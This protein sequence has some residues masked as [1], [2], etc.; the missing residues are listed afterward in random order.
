MQSIEPLCER[1]EAVAASVDADLWPGEPFRLL[2]EEG[3]LGWVIPAEYGGADAS[4][5]E[6]MSGYERLS[7]ACLTTAFVLTQRNGACQRIAASDNETLK[8]ELLPGLARGEV[9]ATV[10]ISHLTTSRQHLAR[11]A[12]RLKATSDGY[13]AEGT[14]PWV[15][16]ANRAQYVVTGGICDDGLGVLFALPLGSPGINVQPPPRLL[17][18]NGSQT[19]SIELADVRIENRLVLAGPVEGVM[20]RGVG[21]ATGGYATSALALGRTASILK[22]LRIES[23][24]RAE[25]RS[26]YDTFDFERATLSRDL[27]SALTATES[28]TD[29]GLDTET[30]RQRAN[31]LVLRSSQAFLA[32]SKGA[33]FVS[34]HPAEQAVR[35][36]MFFLVWSCPQPVL[37]AALAE[38]ACLTE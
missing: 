37:S 16:G 13:I 34:G 35:E 8:A 38:F 27:Q 4:S 28:T 20:K 5:L 32:A 26:I 23:E 21:G 31:S 30:I 36:A 14:V 18:L 1:L 3:V 24:R 6:I 7:S 10:G 17:A 2:A 11:P 19:S 15:T 22:M 29:A 12:V 9:F 25:L 33:G